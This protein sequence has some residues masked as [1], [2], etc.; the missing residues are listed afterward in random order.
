[1]KAHPLIRPNGFTHRRTDGEVSCAF[2]SFRS[3]TISIFVISPGSSVI[4]HLFAQRGRDAGQIA[5][6]ADGPRLVERFLEHGFVLT[7][8]GGRRQ[9]A[10][11]GLLPEFSRQRLQNAPI[12]HRD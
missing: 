4:N 3:D 11:W 8:A 6:G 7:A 5:G 12:I 10:R 1:V 9:P 2:V